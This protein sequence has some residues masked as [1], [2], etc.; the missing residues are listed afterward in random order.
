MQTKTTTKTVVD[1]KENLGKGDQE[2]DFE[3][4]TG[5]DTI[6]EETIE[7]GD[8]E[9]SPKASKETGRSTKDDI[10]SVLPKVEDVAAPEGVAGIKEESPE[11]LEQEKVAIEKEQEK[12]RKEMEAL[13]EESGTVS[14]SSAAATDDAQKSKNPVVVEIEGVME[15]GLD[16]YFF[17][18]TPDERK[19]FKRVGEETAITVMGLLTQAKVHVVKILAAITN[20][21]K[22]LPG[23]NKYFLEQESKIKTDTLLKMKEEGMF[24]EKVDQTDENKM[25]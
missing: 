15:D 24:D 8:E 23:V 18:L 4:D 13:K 17:K 5:S 2:N 21:L 20:W 11:V 1:D 14:S 10:L 3:L 25:S 16:E 6:E 19:E 9:I 12:V 22:M 7:D